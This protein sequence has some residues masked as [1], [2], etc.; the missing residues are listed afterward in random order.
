[1]S[2]RQLK[3]REG[4]EVF[5]GWDPPLRTFF[6]QVYDLSIEDEDEQ[7]LVWLGTSFRELESAG[8]TLTIIQTYTEGELD[9]VLDA[10]T[11]DQKKNL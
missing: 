4:F 1:M 9:S 11:E 10:L 6:A 8:H 2:R 5:V 7:L 3:A